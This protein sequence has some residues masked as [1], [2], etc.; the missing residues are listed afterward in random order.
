MY[1]DAAAA[2]RCMTFSTRGRAAMSSISGLCWPRHPPSIS[3]AVARARDVLERASQL[4]PYRPHAYQPAWTLGPG[5]MLDVARQ[6]TGADAIEWWWLKPP[7]ASMDWQAQFQLAI[8]T[9]HAFQCLV[10]DEEVEPIAH[11]DPPRASRPHGPARV[12]D[13][14]SRLP[15]VGKLGDGRR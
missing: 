8:M 12:R 3:A 6:R 9:G 4:G 15:S 2:A 14:Q 5:M 7:A 10:P 1:S 13:P 11:R